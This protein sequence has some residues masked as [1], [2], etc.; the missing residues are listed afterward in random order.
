VKARTES[1][2]RRNTN[3]STHQRSTYRRKR[4]KYRQL[5]QKR[6]NKLMPASERMNKLIQA[7]P[8]KCKSNPKTS[9]LSTYLGS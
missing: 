4:R 6:M 8:N 9:I 3:G 1:R 7:Q 5:E 2:Q